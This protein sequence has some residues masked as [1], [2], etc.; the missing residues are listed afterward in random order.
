MAVA[1][2]FALAQSVNTTYWESLLRKSGTIITMLVGLLI[3]LAVIWFIWNVFGYIRA[4]NEEKKAEAAKG[5]IWGIVGLAVIVSVWGLVNLLQFTF[6]INGV[7]S[8]D[9]S[10]LLPNT[11]QR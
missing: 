3:A 11:L 5:M 4:A 10:G 8:V 2:L 6:Q 9:T 1:P 7:Q